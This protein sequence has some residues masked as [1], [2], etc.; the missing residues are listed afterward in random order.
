M[1]EV[2]LREAFSGV[3]LQ[4]KEGWTPLHCACAEGNLEIIIFLGRC[5]AGAGEERT[6]EQLKAL[7]ITV[8]DW[9]YSPDGPIDLIPLNADGETLEDIAFDGKEDEIGKILADLKKRYPPSER[10]TSE[11]EPGTDAEEEDLSDEEEDDDDDSKEDEEPPPPRKQ[12]AAK[13]QIKAGAVYAAS[14]GK[15]TRSGPGVSE[16]ASP[17]KTDASPLLK[18]PS[19]ASKV[20]S[21][22]P[23]SSDCS[24]DSKSTASEL[25]GSKPNTFAPATTTVSSTISETKA[26]DVTKLSTTS[27][28]ALYGK[29]EPTATTSTSVTPNTASE[30]CPPKAQGSDSISKP[31]PAVGSGS[32]ISI[33]GKPL[34]EARIVAHVK[35]SVTTTNTELSA[36]PTKEL[37]LLTEGVDV[38]LTSSRNQ[39]PIHLTKSIQP[40]TRRNFTPQ[41]LH[42]AAESNT[43]TTTSPSTRLPIKRD[44]SEKTAQSTV[45]TTALPTTAPVGSLSSESTEST[46]PSKSPSKIT[47]PSSKSSTSPRKGSTDEIAEKVQGGGNQT[48]TPQQPEKQSQQPSSSS[49]PLQ[50]PACGTRRG[51]AEELKTKESGKSG[52]S[53]MA[54]ASPQ[55]H[56]QST[57]THSISE[58]GL[59]STKPES[60]STSKA[61]DSPR[62]NLAN[63]VDVKQSA[64]TATATTASNTAP[65]KF[66]TGR[67][68]D[69]TV[70]AIS[71]KSGS[72]SDV[73]KKEEPQQTSPRTSTDA[74]PSTAQ[75]QSTP[76]EHTSSNQKDGD[77]DLG[78]GG[79]EGSFFGR[80]V[81]QLCRDG[82]RHKI[83]HPPTH[84]R[85]PKVAAP[86]ELRLH[87]SSEDYSHKQATTSSATSSS[88]SPVSSQF[89]FSNQ[90]LQSSTKAELLSHPPPS[91]NSSAPKSVRNKTLSARIQSF[92]SAFNSAATAA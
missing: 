92:I 46:Q 24:T 71:T 58:S 16:K 1:A 59:P 12:C 3:N 65:A 7:G 52:I 72:P 56:S 38:V 6:P 33:T 80:K 15:P 57:K 69:P 63:D 23:R 73:S 87:R 31:D 32:K 29:K 84:L 61:A 4:D 8:D 14:A 42:V 83:H 39:H 86:A 54:T 25:L 88:M 17:S 64:A 85:L 91:C 45:S 28:T 36:L 60:A 10:E 74:K 20:S 22:Q 78:G 44:L 11:E 21:A 49:H 66:A 51:S 34:A 68:E 5:E 41:N 35:S 37:E 13:T 55:P 81:C 50:T 53:S 40:P 30:T 43:I 48:L 75:R 90:P 82:G 67:Y 19:P 27:D 76:L 89:S 2:L 9:I 26:E 62:R 79:G 70:P 77:A 18:L 47:T